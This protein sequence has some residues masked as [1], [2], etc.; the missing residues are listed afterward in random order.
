MNGF[1]CTKLFYEANG[2]GHAPAHLGDFPINVT[3][4]SYRI[5]PLMN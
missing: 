2:E 5:K 3:D 4:A 1:Q